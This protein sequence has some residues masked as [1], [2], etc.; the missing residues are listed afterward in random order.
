MYKLQV[1]MCKLE[2]DAAEVT[3]V[4]A[5]KTAKDSSLQYSVLTETDFFATT[6]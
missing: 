1:V 5:K 3:I 2:Q 6:L 4:I